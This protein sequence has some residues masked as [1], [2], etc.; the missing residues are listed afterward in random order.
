MYYLD[1]SD[2][3]EQLV[4]AI[5]FMTQVQILFLRCVQC[6]PEA[7][8]A[9]ET[10]SSPT[11][12]FAELKTLV[13]FQCKVPKPSNDGSTQAWWR[14]LRDALRMRMQKGRRL[15]KLVLIPFNWYR[16]ESSFSAELL[17]DL[18][19]VVEDVVDCQDKKRFHP[20]L[21]GKCPTPFLA[22]LEQDV[23]MWM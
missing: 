23:E 14:R 16:P 3:K 1:Y 2:D 12:F 18:R 20:A 17:A 15:Q 6:L 4:N 9:V 7:L 10:S 5:G 11:D 8:E 22:Q 21:A 13:L 19:E